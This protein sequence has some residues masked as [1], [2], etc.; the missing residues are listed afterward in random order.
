MLWRS[1]SDLEKHKLTDQ[2]ALSDRDR[3]L[4]DRCVLFLE[5]NLEY[6][7]PI[8]NFRMS[9]PPGTVAIALWAGMLLFGLLIIDREGGTIAILSLLGLALAALGRRKS[10][11]HLRKMAQAGD[12]ESWPFLRPL[13]YE[14]AANRM[15]S[16]TA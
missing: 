4:F 14:S 1:Y 6:Q 5:A 3:M 11:H 2:H 7:W 12:V 15:N 9:A 16:R 10:R 8:D 13:D